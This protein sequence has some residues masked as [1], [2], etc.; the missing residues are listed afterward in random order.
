M[1]TVPSPVLKRLGLYTKE[2]EERKGSVPTGTEWVRARVKDVHH[3][4]VWNKRDDEANS[5]KLKGLE[6]KVEHQ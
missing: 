6:I 2:D 3:R 1:Q 4:K 5:F